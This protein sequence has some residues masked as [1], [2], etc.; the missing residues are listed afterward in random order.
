MLYV[1]IAV[2]AWLVWRAQP[3]FGL[4]LGLWSAQLALNTLWSWL[5]FGL[6]RPGLAAVDIILLLGTI[7]ATAYAFVRVSRLAALM[8]LPYALW[9]GFATALNLAIWRLNA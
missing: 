8:L 4:P 5:F 3:R 7:V 2:S 1:M 9:V 6:E